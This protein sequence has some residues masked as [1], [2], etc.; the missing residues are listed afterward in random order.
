MRQVTKDQGCIGAAL[1][2]S[3]FT[4]GREDSGEMASRCGNC[5]T[6][7]YEASDGALR[8]EVPEEKT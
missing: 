1:R 5:M 7:K 3:W 2:H 6:V 8:Y 4:L